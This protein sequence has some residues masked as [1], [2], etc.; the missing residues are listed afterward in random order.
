M[1]AALGPRGV[2]WPRPG[3]RDPGPRRAEGGRRGGRPAPPVPLPGMRGAP[4]TWRR[5]E[6]SDGRSRLTGAG[7]AAGRW[8]SASRP[9]GEWRRRRR[10]SPQRRAGEG[11][12]GERKGGEAGVAPPPRAPTATSARRGRAGRRGGKESGGGGPVPA[13]PFFLSGAPPAAAPR[14]PRRAGGG[15]G[16]GR[17]SPRLERRVPAS[18]SCP[19][20]SSAG[21]APGAAGPAALRPREPPGPCGQGRSCEGDAAGASPGE[22]SGVA[23]PAGTDKAPPWGARL[24]GGGSPG[25]R[26]RRGRSPSGP[27]EP[28]VPPWRGCA[29]DEPRSLPPA[30]AAGPAA[31]DRSAG[32][33]TRLPGRGGP[34]ASP[35]GP[36]P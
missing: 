33:R 27:P 30:G 6:A 10:R 19:V 28:P 15:S 7:A 5:R 12:S 32:R 22:R 25:G 29:R 17:G 24:P 8:G 20:P 26:G 21:W 13:A 3:A 18:R 31:F 2:C 36:A 34:A 11:R 4:G 1:P 35:G 16:S 23:L 14:Q 9:P